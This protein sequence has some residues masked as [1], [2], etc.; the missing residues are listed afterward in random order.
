MKLATIRTHDGTA[1]VRV[2]DD[3]AV[4]LGAADLG[5]WLARPGW[6]AAAEQAD[7]PRHSLAG[8]DYAPLIPSPEKVI[9]VGL[10]YRTHIL[11]MGRELP[12][13]PALF[14]KFARALVG[15]FDPVELP[16]GSEQ[17]DWEAELGVVIGAEVRHATPERAAAAIAGYTAI[18]DV[19]ARDFQYRSVQW[20]QGKTFERS[21]PVGPWLVTD[22]DPGE[23]S[24]EVDGDLVQQADTG[25]LVFNPAELVAYISQIITLA[26]GDIIATGTPGGVGHARKPPRYLRQGSELVTR[27]EGVGEL[28]NTMVRGS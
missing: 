26:P 18:N 7:G 12:A 11:E 5:A 13:Y 22:A 2:D 16:S 23:I 28:R 1:A 24:C 9:C 6:K 14:A 3:G 19:T 27:V 10:N 20:L 4:E 21:T 25:D 15:A 8:L 17:V